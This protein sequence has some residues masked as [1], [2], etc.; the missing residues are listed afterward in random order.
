MVGSDALQATDRDGLVLDSAATARGLAGAVANATENSGENVRFA[1]QQ[2]CVCKPALRDESNVLRNVR[3]RRARPLAIDY[4]VK[5][6]G[7]VGV[8]R[9]HRAALDREELLMRGWAV[10]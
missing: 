7:P 1:V 6:L 5:I 10:L 2:V 4:A 9:I 8:G 3:V